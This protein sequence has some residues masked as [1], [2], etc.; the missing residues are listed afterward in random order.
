MAIRTID[1]DAVAKFTMEQHRRKLAE[2]E[3]GKLRQLNDIEKAFANLRDDGDLPG[4]LMPWIDTQD[5]FSFEMGAVTL[6]A[7]ING[8][9]KSTFM[10]QVFIHAAHQVQ[11]GCMSL[12]MEIHRQLTL[13]SQ[14]AHAKHFP[15]R[16]EVEG[17]QGYLNEKG[18]WFYDHFGT[19]K[20]VQVYGALWAFSEKGCGMVVLDNLQ[21]C[22][23][24]SDHDVE[25]AF[26]A[27]I[28]GI[29][30][31]SGMHIVLVHHVRKPSSDNKHY[32]PTKYDVRG[33]G[34]LT[35]QPDNCLIV[36]HNKER[37]KHFD[38]KRRAL[39]SPNRKLSVWIS[40]MILS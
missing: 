13:M 37:K 23:V 2:A 32:R 4:V 35:D 27:E 16:D 15:T 17:T 29:A 40:S 26:T 25:R 14:Q 39:R 33:S 18:A 22:G 36:W 19:V 38:L 8:H 3:A 10:S 28:C 34:S 11:L 20:P 21:K 31:A 5:K 24:T 7:G 9:M 12:E 6:L 30:K 1:H